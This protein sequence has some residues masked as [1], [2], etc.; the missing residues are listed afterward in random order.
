MARLV[1]RFPDWA[2]WKKDLAW[3]DDQLARLDQ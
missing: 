3:L 1:A 2:Q